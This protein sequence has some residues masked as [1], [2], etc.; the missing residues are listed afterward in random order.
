MW[1]CKQKTKA[2]RNRHPQTEAERRRRE[3]EQREIR[4][5]WS[6]TGDKQEPVDDSQ[7]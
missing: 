5:F 3:R 6:Y 2:K 4:N 1:P 7:L